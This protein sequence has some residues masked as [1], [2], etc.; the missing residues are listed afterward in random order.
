MQVNFSLS[1]PE[2]GLEGGWN[3]RLGRAWARMLRSLDISPSSTAV[4]VGPGFAAKVGFGLAELGFRGTLILVEP[5]EVARSW[6]VRRYRRLLPHAEVLALAAS[7][8]DAASIA[9]RSVD[10]L[11]ANHLLDDLLLNAA[12]PQRDGA[13]L[14][15]QMRPGAECSGAF[16]EIWRRLLHTPKRLDWLVGS[17]AEDFSHFINA[18]RPRVM[19]LNQ[20]PSWRHQ[21]HGLGAI[22]A[23]SLRVMRLL[24]GKIGPDR[25][26]P[27][28]DTPFPADPVRWLVRTPE[29]RDTQ[30]PL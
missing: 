18:V 5:N 21:S 3:R 22:H 28:D 30:V 11:M 26:G 15:A 6:V 23:H 10:L 4:E 20:Y 19:V 2:A 29:L 14:F 25:L 27:G 7:V 16:V 1:E 12:V 24:S 8:P 9:G 13:Q 17:V